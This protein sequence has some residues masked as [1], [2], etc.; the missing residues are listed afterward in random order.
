MGV[1]EKKFYD[2]NLRAGDNIAPPIVTATVVGATGTTEYSYRVTF[3]TLVGETTPTEP[4]VVT[5]GYATLGLTNYVRLTVDSAPAAAT[6]I[7]FYKLSDQNYYLLQEVSAQ[8]LT[9][10]DTGQQVQSTYL[11]SYTSNTSGR[12]QWRA[13][14]FNP[15]KHLQRQELIDLQW[16][17]MRSIRDLGN[18]THRNG[19][20]INGCQPVFVEGTTWRFTGGQ[21]YIDGQIVDVPE[22]E[23][24]LVGTGIEVV[25]LAITPVVET[26]L[27][28]QHMRNHDEGVDLAYAE[29]GADRLVYNI[30]WVLDQ[31]GQ[32]DIQKFDTN[33]VMAK[34]ISPE[35]T[36]LIETLA[37]RT[38][39]VHGSFITEPFALE[40][41]AHPSDDTKCIL[42][43][44]RGKAYVD[45]Y[46]T[47]TIGHREIPINKG[48]DIRAY[49]DS[50][51][52]GY[53]SYGGSVIAEN[54]QN[55]DVDGLKVSLQVGSGHVHDV[56]LNGSGQTAAQVATQINDAINARKTAGQPDIITAEGLLSGYL[57]LR[58][59]ADKD[60]S[61]L[62]ISGDAYS[63]LGLSL[64]TYTPTGTR[65]Y[66]IF[67]SNVKS[68]SSLSYSSEQVISLTYNG[69]IGG[70]TLSANVY[71]L[72]GAAVAESDCHDGYFDYREGVDF[73]L[74]MYGGQ[75]AILF[76][77]GGS[78]PTGTYYLKLRESRAGVTGTRVL[79]TV[80]DEEIIKGAYQGADSLSKADV[81]RITKVAN[82]A[83]GANAWTE[84]QLDK[85]STGLA[86]DYSKVD[87]SAAGAQGVGQPSTGSHYFVSYQY[88]NHTVEGD[89]V[90]ADS[91]SDYELIELAPDEETNLRDCV[92]F[93]TTSTHRPEHGEQTT[94]DYE[95]YLPRF[96][97]VGFA[98]DGTIALIPGIAST[99]PTVPLDQP[100][101]LT[102][103]QVYVPAY[104]YSHSE[105][106]IRNIGTLRTTQAGIKNLSDEIDRL[107]YWQLIN[108]LENQTAYSDAAVGAKGIFTD[109]VTG[110]GKLSWSFDKGG[111][112]HTAA[113]DAKAREV[114]LPVTI[115]QRTIEIDEGNSTHIDF[116]GNYIVKGYQPV[117]HQQSLGASRKIN[118]NP[119]N[120]W[121]PFNGRLT[122]S[123]GFDMFEDITQLPTATV[124][125][126][127]NMAAVLNILDSDRI[128]QINWGYWNPT[129]E[130][131][132][133]TR[134]VGHGNWQRWEQ[135]LRERQGDRINSIV[136]ETQ[137]LD[138]GDRV[139]D[140]S[141]IQYV[142]TRNP[143]T[144]R[145]TI[146]VTA[147]SLMLNA[148]HGCEIAGISVDLTPTG[149]SEAGQSLYNGKATVVAD[150]TG[151]LT[152]EFE[153]P[154]GVP[155][156]SPLV[157]LVHSS[158]G[159]AAS[160]ASAYFYAGGI[161]A[162]HQA[163]TLGMTTARV[164]TS[165]TS[166]RQW[167]DSR[168]IETRYIDPL[169]QTFTVE[170]DDTYISE[171]H[172]YFASKLN[173]TQHPV[174]CEIRTVLNGYPT[175]TVVQSVTLPAS[176]IT[177]SNDASVAA[178]FKFTEVVS[179]QRGWYAVVLMTN[180]TD[181][182]VWAA[183]LGD[184]DVVTG[185]IIRTQP[186]HGVFFH[187]PN[188]STW[189]AV[190]T[191]DLKM[192]IKKSN[193]RQDAS[194]VFNNLTGIQASHLV[195]KVEQF[196][197]PG[198]QASWYYSLD[199]GVSWIPHRPWLDSY[200]G[201]IASEVRLRCTVDG[202]NSGF[203]VVREFN[204]I[205]FLL[206]ESTAEYIS[207]QIYF[208]DPNEL[209]NK[210]NV[211]LDLLTDG[212][213]G[214]GAR[215]V[216]PYYSV[217]DGDTWC[218]LFPP[219]GYSPINKDFDFWEWEFGTRPIDGTITNT[220]NA[221]PIVVTCTDHGFQT[222]E[223]VVVAN[224]VGNTGANNTTNNPYWV[225]T[226]IDANSFSLNDS[227][228][229]GE[230]ASGGTVGLAG[231]EQCRLRIHLETSNQA[232]TPIVRDIRMICSER[233]N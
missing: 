163:T 32:L 141:L 110:Q 169:A 182:E 44:Q 103:A 23:V 131:R 19:D 175:E 42:R 159:A 59:Q 155:T 13:V 24:E 139:V 214:T 83:G 227:T 191:Q 152:A 18:V 213:N 186:H 173:N 57:F 138:L 71:D 54:E 39:D 233:S 91:Y 202:S 61:I 64:G 146:S 17:L 142:R 198:V 87:W 193:F 85:N 153:M 115:A 217:D 43:V 40:A 230:Y 192:V 203:A 95:R 94:F 67:D 205:V 120:I 196:T 28:D 98:S 65:I 27:T 66:E 147:D 49:E 117:L 200:L 52:G 143:D 219:D 97:K 190:T 184:T 78:H 60:L 76:D 38:R 187:S 68:V 132:E 128:G 204:G 180:C 104:T 185:Q 222:N 113:I 111:I 30:T 188:G 172:V 16:I 165:N 37:R 171:V 116:V 144:S 11:Q 73:R 178:E 75:K 181:Y 12:P 45:G 211:Y 149:D 9:F 101:I 210:V 21:V 162:H 228:G 93:R 154:D 50:M 129:G 127:N 8:T 206:H 109:P 96:D 72:V 41:L 35:R 90:G 102:I 158:E 174:T 74:G 108:N 123:P 199:N 216:T 80:T 5:T 134:V 229:S 29:D 7:R 207:N 112:K 107:K 126:D 14:L 133:Q 36:E 121:N 160:S 34:T 148:E 89:F 232:L 122:L 167:F 224:V 136:P 130:T 189:Q 1:L 170:E 99:P 106:I 218:E 63:V 156:G 26:H 179:Y 223:R 208:T 88:W 15:G 150:A 81:V 10:N 77:L 4:I 56:T 105:M 124:N 6:H 209:P 48:R 3:V 125:Y 20:V 118:L 212:I 215:T 221:S 114:K 55:Y 62:A 2:Y 47:E 195:T 86:H 22:G 92:D 25:G 137:F 201:S 151:H 135:E 46:E 225:V 231:M 220:T 84:Y 161:S 166:E 58:A 69:T 168:L 183:Q 157:R 119:D 226:R 100:G 145:F 177:A 33:V 70:N 79:T 164:N 53:E 194:L 176:S 197:G 51:I 31:A 82:S 140:I